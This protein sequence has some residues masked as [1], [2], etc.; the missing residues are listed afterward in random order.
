M[1]ALSRR[2]L[3]ACSLLAV[4]ISSA[5]ASEAG[6][7]DAPKDS[8]ATRARAADAIVVATVR[9]VSYEMSAPASGA[10]ALPFTFVTFEV[11]SVLKG[12]LAERPLVLRFLGGSF[13]DGRF[14]DDPTAPL[15]DVGEK[16]ILLVTQEIAQATALDVPLAGDRFGRLRVIDGRVYDDFGKSITLVDGERVRLGRTIRHDEVTHHVVAGGR[17]FNPRLREVPP[18]PADKPA[19]KPADLAGLTVPG[20]D[21]AAVANA[22]TPTPDEAVSLA[23]MSDWLRAQP[24]SGPSRTVENQDPR[25][26]FIARALRPARR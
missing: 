1:S 11:E 14:F 20:S 9:D 15:F 16:S 4:V 19:D 6:A 13:P 2:S 25:K 12:H 10:P 21:E 26:P 23:S 8:L 5:I 7:F 3:L 22:A 24:A 18:E 17:S